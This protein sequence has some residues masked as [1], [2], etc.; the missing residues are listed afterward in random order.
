[1]EYPERSGEKGGWPR[2]VI[3]NQNIFRYP[4]ADRDAVSARPLPPREE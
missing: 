1:M 2:V 4:Q 3:Y